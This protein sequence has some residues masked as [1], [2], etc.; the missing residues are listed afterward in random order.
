MEKD[1]KIIKTNLSEAEALT[2]KLYIEVA[3]LSDLLRTIS[4]D[5]EEHSAEIE[6]ISSR[7]DIACDD[8]EYLEGIVS[9]KA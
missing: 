7:L 1:I 9:K 3:S 5:D 2:R 8:M 4:K 6:Y